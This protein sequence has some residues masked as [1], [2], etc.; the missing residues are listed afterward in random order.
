[1]SRVKP[2]NSKVNVNQQDNSSKIDAIKDL[3]FGDTINEYDSEFQALKK[4][5]LR[6]KKELE[7]LMSDVKED[8]LNSIDGLNTDISTRIT[9]LEDDL[10]TRAQKLEDKKIDKKTLGDL[11]VKL[12]EKIGQ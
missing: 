11:L 5:L 1:M 4:D 12:G 2:I 7:T 9:N 3:L 6:K 8:L 10:S